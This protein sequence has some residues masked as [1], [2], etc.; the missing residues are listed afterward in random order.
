MYSWAGVM[1]DTGLAHLRVFFLSVSG[2]AEE[3]QDGHSYE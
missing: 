3:E 2:L 1:G